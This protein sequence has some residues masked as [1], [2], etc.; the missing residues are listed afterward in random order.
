VCTGS[1]SGLINNFFSSGSQVYISGDL[2]YHDARAVE[3]ANLSLI[4]IGHFASE[5]LIVEVLAERLQKVLVESEF[6]VK[7]EACKLEK[8]PFVILES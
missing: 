1:G 6:D 5:H 2:R 3:A 4:D 7:V 8:D